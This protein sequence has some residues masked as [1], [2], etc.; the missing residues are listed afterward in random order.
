MLI[1]WS[2]TEGEQVGSYLYMGTAKDN[3]YKEMMVYSCNLIFT[4]S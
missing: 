4:I 2:V 1:Y 3:G